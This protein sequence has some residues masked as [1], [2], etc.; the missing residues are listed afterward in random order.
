MPLHRS[1]PRIATID[2]GRA[3]IMT[4]V[5]MV[6]RV[7]KK[8]QNGSWSIAGFIKTNEAPQMIATLTSAST[9]N[10]EDVVGFT[11]SHYRAV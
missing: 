3:M 7:A 1:L 9:A 6:K 5:A 11:R 8:S 2:F 4:S 10:R